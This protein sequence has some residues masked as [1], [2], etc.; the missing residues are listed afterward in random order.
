MRAVQL[1]LGIAACVIGVFLMVHAIP[2]WI[3]APSN[4]RNIVLSP[5]FWPYILSGLT[6][7]VGLG[8]LW[9]G[10]KAAPDDGPANPPIDDPRSGVRRLVAMAA[11][12]A[13]TF[14]LLP[15][16]GMVWVAMLAFV[17]LAFLIRTRHRVAA[18][19]CAVVVPL[20]LYGFF[21]HVAGVAI[22][23]GDYVRLP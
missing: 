8:L 16:L 15:R 10:R 17:A 3:S 12:M 19:V 7:L 11:L 4:M 13:V 5:R 6:V 1:Q 21:A 9:T 14:W 20:V 18:V 23:Q 22:P 2:H